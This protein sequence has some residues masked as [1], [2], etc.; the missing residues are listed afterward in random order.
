VFGGVPAGLDLLDPLVAEA[1]ADALAW[2]ISP[3]TNDPDF[4]ATE[5]MGRVLDRARDLR[6]TPTA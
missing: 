1:L 4:M 6:E 2:R 5:P 3:D